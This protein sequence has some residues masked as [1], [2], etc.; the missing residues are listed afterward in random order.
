MN[1]LKECRSLHLWVIL[2]N[3]LE[4]NFADKKI[5]GKFLE[6]STEIYFSF[7][8]IFL[9]GNIKIAHDQLTSQ[10]IENIFKL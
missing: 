7:I 4:K 3:S 5:P 10:R 2:R 9:T 1:P 8:K 6:H